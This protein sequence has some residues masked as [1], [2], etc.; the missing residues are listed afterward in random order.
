MARCG[1]LKQ[2]F[3]HMLSYDVHDVWEKKEET[4][5]CSVTSHV[6]IS[7]NNL[8]KTDYKR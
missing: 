5:S 1:E 8:G 6:Q 4:L 2:Q 7:L 3:Q